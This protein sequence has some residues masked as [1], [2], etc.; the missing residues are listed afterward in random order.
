MLAATLPRCV[1]SHVDAEGRDAGVLRVH[2][3]RHVTRRR[4]GVVSRVDGGRHDDAHFDGGR[5]GDAEI[6]R[7]GNYCSRVGPTHANAGRMIGP[8]AV[9]GVVSAAVMAQTMKTTEATCVRW[10]FLSL[11]P[12]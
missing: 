2:R 4:R 11:D 8:M 6:V 7:R 10:L 5:H 12:K 3:G 1:V 9:A